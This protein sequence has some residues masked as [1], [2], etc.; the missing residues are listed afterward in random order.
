[1][2]LCT[3]C[4]STPYYPSVGHCIVYCCHR[5]FHNL[6][7]NKRESTP[8]FSFFIYHHIGVYGFERLL[9]QNRY[10]MD[11]KFYLPYLAPDVEVVAI[12]VEHGFANSIEDPVENPEQEW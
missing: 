3:I 9:T 11:T 1:M 7:I 4:A 8:H 6:Q 2:W 5:S 10:T 12:A